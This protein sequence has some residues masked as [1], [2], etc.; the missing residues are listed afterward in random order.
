MLCNSVVKGWLV[1]SKTILLKLSEHRPNLN[2]SLA[3]KNLKIFSNTKG[4]RISSG[5]FFIPPFMLLNAR[6]SLQ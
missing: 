1:I 5:G 2:I 4:G 6:P 3:D